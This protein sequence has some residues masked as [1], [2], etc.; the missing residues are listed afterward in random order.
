MYPEGIP[1]DAVPPRIERS[2]RSAEFPAGT[3]GSGQDAP[4]RTAFALRA[5]LRRLGGGNHVPQVL[6]RV[7]VGASWARLRHRPRDDRC[8]RF[9]YGIIGRNGMG[10]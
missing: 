9:W 4:D 3:A 2:P 7:G 1:A 5:F 10:M 6:I 8:R